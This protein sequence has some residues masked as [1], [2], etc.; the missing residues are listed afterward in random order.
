MYNRDSFRFSG[1][2]ENAEAII[3]AIA[4]VEHPI[5][6][7]VKLIIKTFSY[8]GTGNVLQVQDLL[9]IAGTL[10]GFFFPHRGC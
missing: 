2:G 9:S 3:E 5:A 10:F 4:I 7:S 6:E 8:A 1:R